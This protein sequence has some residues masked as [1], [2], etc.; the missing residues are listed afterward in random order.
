M[1]ANPSSIPVPIV[2][3]DLRE[4]LMP[5]V[6][7]VVIASEAVSLRRANPGWSAMQILD[8]A[9]AGKHGTNPEFECD[10]PDHDDCLE[11]PSP[12]ADLIREAFAPDVEWSDLVLM[13][14]EAG[15]P[16]D[17]ARRWRIQHR[18][19]GAI[20]KFAERYGLWTTVSR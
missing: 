6:D 10:H 17:G 4:S 14:R 8:D 2:M 11:P 5:A 16:P 13:R 3:S 15:N 20:D 12:F 18:W 19:N 9:M 1:L 7:G